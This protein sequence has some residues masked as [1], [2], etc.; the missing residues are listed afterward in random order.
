M[1]EVVAASYSADQIMEFDEPGP[2][3]Q[4]VVAS[5]DMMMVQQ[6]DERGPGGH[7]DHGEVECV[8]NPSCCGVSSTH[9]QSD[10]DQAMD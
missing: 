10:I 7:H 3:Q 1:E 8:A 5:D 6:A 9:C 2:E 4:H